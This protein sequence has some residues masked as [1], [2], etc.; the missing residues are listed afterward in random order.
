MYG[1]NLLGLWLYPLNIIWSLCAYGDTHTEWEKD[2]QKQVSLYKRYILQFNVNYIIYLWMKDFMVRHSV[3]VL[4]MFLL[5]T[6][7][8]SKAV[9]SHAVQCPAW[10][11]CSD[12]SC[13]CILAAARL[14]LVRWC[15]DL[16][17]KSLFVFNW[18]VYNWQSLYGSLLL[19]F[20][21]WLTLS[22]SVNQALSACS[23]SL[24]HVTQNQVMWSVY[25]TC[26]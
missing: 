1:I 3:S 10:V 6:A 12:R 25:I 26:I 2:M 11:Y 13:S 24:L 8:F 15:K 5:S 22:E 16:F 9:F 19:S 20:F 21:L 17:S 7:P 23:C 18:S 4:A 14:L